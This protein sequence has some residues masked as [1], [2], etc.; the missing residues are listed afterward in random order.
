MKKKNLFP[1]FL[2]LVA[3][4]AL[5]SAG[6]VAP[7]KENTTFNPLSTSNA[8]KNAETTQTPSFVSEVTLSD[9]TATPPAAQGYTTFLPTTQIPADITCRIHSLTL[10]G[11][12]GSAFI[13]NLKNAPMYINYTVV[14]QNTTVTKVYTNP[15]TK[16]TETLI[17]SDYSPT[18]WF[19]VTVRDNATKELLLQDGFG[20]KKG[21]SIYL[22]RTLKVMKNGD[23]LVE[24][25]GND[26]R[27]GASVWVKP[28]GNVD[29][30]RLSEFTDCMYWDAN[31]DTIA[32]PVPTT[33]KDA[34]YTWTP[35]N[36][37]TAESAKSA[38]DY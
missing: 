26:I 28:L 7:P 11:Y 31:R 34:I 27:A 25:R 14:P 6:C 10:F 32:T 13:F 35:E 9:V 5:L 12:N 4:L 22:T 17:Y 29:D 23:L 8:N 36:K 21:Y 19:E 16:K 15:N 33:I 20:P 24:F 30:S 2:A 37:A 18:S 38:K 3:I 1:A